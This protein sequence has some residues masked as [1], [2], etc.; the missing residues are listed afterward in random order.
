VFHYIS[1]IGREGIFGDQG[2]TGNHCAGILLVHQKNIWENADGPRNYSTR[3]NHGES[4]DNSIAQ[5]AVIS[6]WNPG[7]TFQEE[8]HNGALAFPFSATEAAAANQSCTFDFLA[9]IDGA[10]ALKDVMLILADNRANFTLPSV[11][12]S[13]SASSERYSHTKSYTGVG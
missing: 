4:N 6:F 9:G 11:S 3:K 2:S 8:I 1:V 12:H 10:R 7:K 13:Q 5:G